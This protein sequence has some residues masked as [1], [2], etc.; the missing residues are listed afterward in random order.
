MVEKLAGVYEAE[1]HPVIEEALDCRPSV[2]IDIGTADGYYA[3]GFAR[4]S[5]AE[6]FGFELAPRAR[7][8]CSELARLNEVS[9]RLHGRASSRQLRALPL[10]GAFILSD[11]EGAEADIFDEAIVTALCTAL[12]VIE[13]HEWARPG[14]ER[15]LVDRF[16]LSH[17]VELI[18]GSTP[19]PFR[20]D[21]GRWLVLR[22]RSS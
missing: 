21:E 12:V 5:N 17:H 6:V 22:P 9:V 15:L 16:E 1:L 2:L 11:C 19:A 7:R 14:V 3:V 4:Q 18:A 8:L 20:L 10:T 13:V